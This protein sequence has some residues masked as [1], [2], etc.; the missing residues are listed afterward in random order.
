MKKAKTLAYI[1]LNNHCRL[2]TSRSKKEPS[3]KV[4]KLSEK[5]FFIYLSLDPESS[6]S[7]VFFIAFSIFPLKKA[8]KMTHFRST[9]FWFG[10]IKFMILS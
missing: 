4:L 3:S 9:I 2:T 6:S 10:R 1:F 8:S 5:V 7:F